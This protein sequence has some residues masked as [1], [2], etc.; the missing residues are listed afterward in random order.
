MINKLLLPSSAN[1]QLESLTAACRLEGRIDGGWLRCAAASGILRLARAHDHGLTAE[2]Y[3]EL[4]L[5]LQVG[6]ERG[7]SCA[8]CASG[9]YSCGWWSTVRGAEL[10]YLC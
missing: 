6:G 9:L 4:A 1:V 2:Q 3:V 5:S 7:W 8:P 10:V